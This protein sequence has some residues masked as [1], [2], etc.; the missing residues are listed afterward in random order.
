[1]TLSIYLVS[2]AIG[3]SATISL[4][5]STSTHPFDNSPCFLLLYQKCMGELGSVS[6]LTL[7]PYFLTLSFNQVYHGGNL[8]TVGLNLGCAFAPTTGSLIGLRFLGI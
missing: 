4:Y 7:Q 5:S 6:L 8:V 1:L 3:V 2:F